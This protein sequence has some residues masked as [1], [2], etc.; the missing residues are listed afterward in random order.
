MLQQ[1]VMVK[2]QSRAELRTNAQD[3]ML[4]KVVQ[5]VD[6][7]SWGPARVAFELVLSLNPEQHRRCPGL[8]SE[9]VSESIGAGLC[10][11]QR[12]AD[13]AVPPDAD[14]REHKVFPVSLERTKVAVFLPMAPLP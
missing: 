11:E 6:G 4:A 3:P 12:S 2:I 7:Q 5:L 9:H 8:A 1:A 10:R 14:E 13:H